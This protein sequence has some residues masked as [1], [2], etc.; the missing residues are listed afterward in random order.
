MSEALVKSKLILM[1]ELSNKAKEIGESLSHQDIQNIDVEDVRKIIE[2]RSNEIQYLESFIS[3][4]GVIH[5]IDVAIRAFDECQYL[6]TKSGIN[7]GRF[8]Y[9]SVGD[10]VSSSYTC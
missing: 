6:V 8:R 1:K 7:D 3:K 4:I 5:D 10:W 2:E 9:N